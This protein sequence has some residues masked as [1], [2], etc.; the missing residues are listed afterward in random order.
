MVYVL[1]H[2]HLMACS[3]NCSWEN[4]KS[5][6]TTLQR[7]RIM[8][9]VASAGGMGVSLWIIGGC[10]CIGYGLSGLAATALTCASSAHIGT[11]T[12]VSRL[13][14]LANFKNL[15]HLNCSAVLSSYLTLQ[16]IYVY[17]TLYSSLHVYVYMYVFV[18]I[19]LTVYPS[20]SQNNIYLLQHFYF[21]IFVVVFGYLFSVFFARCFCLNLFYLLSNAILFCILVN[22]FV[23]DFSF[24]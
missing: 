6:T 16:P 10:T 17:L 12:Y 2:I 14:V 24:L 21:L 15:L 3:A 13:S 18:F 23:L 1:G 9:D 22:L 20:A 11:Y 4:A 19:Y 7:I 5:T 8:C